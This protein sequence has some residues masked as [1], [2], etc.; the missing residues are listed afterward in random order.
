MVK[1]M[2]S[3]FTYRLNNS[4]LQYVD[5]KWREIIVYLVSTREGEAWLK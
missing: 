2:S 4:T 1:P 3:S 5:Y